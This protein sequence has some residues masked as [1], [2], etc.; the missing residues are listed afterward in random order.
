MSWLSTV[1]RLISLWECSAMVFGSCRA[2]TGSISTAVT[3]H[4]RSSSA[5]VS[6][7]RPGPT[8]RT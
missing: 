4:P 7:P 1:K 2:S 6:D 3:A 5:S 8:S